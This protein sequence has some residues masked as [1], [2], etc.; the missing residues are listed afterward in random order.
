MSI[1]NARVSS[2][3]QISAS[4]R[5]DQRSAITISP[6]TIQLDSILCDSIRFRQWAGLGG[7]LLVVSWWFLVGPGAWVVV[8]FTGRTML[9]CRCRTSFNA[10]TT[11]TGQQSEQFGSLFLTFSL[12]LFCCF[13]SLFVVFVFSR[14]RY[15]CVCGG[16]ENL[17]I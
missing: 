15:M 1:E 2:T 9:G 11:A 12:R 6:W 8:G 17:L 16:G 5:D 4:T 14:A 3:K 7:W 10:S 13:F